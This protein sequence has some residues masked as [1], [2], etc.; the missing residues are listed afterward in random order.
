MESFWVEIVFIELW[1]NCF[2]KEKGGISRIGG[3]GLW[4]FI[5]I[6]RWLGEIGGCDS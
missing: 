6:D 4:F 2:V 5:G 3:E 1:N